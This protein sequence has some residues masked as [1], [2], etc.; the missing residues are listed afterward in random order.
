MSLLLKVNTRTNLHFV[1]ACVEA[2][3]PMGSQPSFSHV[4]TIF[5]YVCVY[6]AEMPG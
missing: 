6:Q 2:I 1:C 3:R 5:Y 4:G